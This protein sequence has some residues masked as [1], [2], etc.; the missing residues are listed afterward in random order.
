MLATGYGNL[1]EILIP[2]SAG[3]GRNT[4]KRLQGQISLERN[5]EASEICRQTGD[6]RLF[7]CSL[8]YCKQ[9][10]KRC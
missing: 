4:R 7:R 8:Y 3:Q 9:D 5:T 6:C 2:H 1:K 10:N